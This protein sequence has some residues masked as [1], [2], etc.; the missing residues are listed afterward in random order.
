MGTKTVTW[1]S[2][3][4]LPC[5]G[6]GARGVLVCINPA[7]ILV[8]G[9]TQG[10]I[11]CGF[12]DA[13]ICGIFTES[14]C[15]AFYTYTFS[16]DDTQLVDQARVVL[17]SDITGA[18]C[19]D[20]L[21]DWMSCHFKPPVCVTDSE[22][23]NFSLDDDGCITGDVIIS[24]DSNNIISIHS[25]GLYATVSGTLTTLTADSG[26]TTT[27]TPV[28]LA[29]GSDITTTRSGNTITITFTGA[30][31]VV[32]SVTNSDGTLTI[33]PTTGAVI[34]SLAL[35]HANTW[36][37][38]QTFGT[39]API[40]SSLTA[41]LPLKLDASKII[42]SAAIDLSTTDV[43][44]NLGVSHLNSGTAASSSTF[45]RGDGTWA[46][47]VGGVTSVANSDGTLTIS[48]TT[49]AVVASLALAHVNTW[50]GQQ[51]FSVS[52]P[53][54]SSLTASLPL[55][56]DASKI[57]ISAAI[58]LSTAE[59]TGNLSVNHLNAGTGASSST[60]WRGD[61]TWVTPSNT[62]TSV[63][64]IDGT[65]TISPTTGAVIASLALAHANTWSGQQTFG[66][67]AP[68]LS[69]L[70]ASLP[71]KL[72]AS[73]IIISAAINLSG[74]EVTGNLPVT[75]LNSGT[76]ASS[77][78]FW[79]GD[80]TWATPVGGGAV[81]SVTNSDGTLTI[82]PTTG[83]VVASIAL[84]HANTWTAKQIFQL[85]TEQLRLGYDV[86]NF[87]A[88]TVSSVGSLNV[89][90]TGTSPEFTLGNNLNISGNIVP[91]GRVQ[92]RTVS[93]ADATSISPNSDTTD[94]LT[95]A[96]TQ[97]LGTL[98]INSPTGSPVA[99]QA[100]VLRIKSTNVQT[101]AWNAI[102]R[103]ASG[104]ALPTATTGSGNT[105]YYSYIYNATDTKWDYT[106]SN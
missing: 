38:Q 58:D 61:G 100:L 79:R 4:L 34:A 57:I 103:N 12:L 55:K 47:P 95:Q 66:T 40:L 30:S 102:Y 6:M 65:L 76:S 1:C 5:I 21:T 45:W 75:N 74:A 14:S 23:I 99:S 80:G 93:V 97:V 53:I 91:T 37:G 83:A 50:S 70:T 52:A 36:S 48:P 69:S 86:S 33:S 81:S 56:L 64:N 17:S 13:L 84:G 88:F 26:G 59:V 29:G 28:T 96:N 106:G 71:L 46:T 42:I 60:F 78:T 44:G 20:C 54:L 24:P 104:G 82:S 9:T 11:E 90:L 87:S 101:F 25:N 63:S 67:A 73:K 85:I 27:G 35:S 31:G 94:I 18:F 2:S 10:D 8:T 43:T 19:R 15:P 32:T 98:T 16:Y 3:T 51:T 77:T 105:N 22:S 39:I 92:K 49:G 72:D 7:D 41:S 68:I 89:T 62:I